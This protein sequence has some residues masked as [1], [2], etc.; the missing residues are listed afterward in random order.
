M[1]VKRYPVIVIGAGPAGAAAC[2][3]L[4]QG[5]ARTLLIEK[6]KLPRKKMCSGLLSRWTV[7]FVHRHFGPIPEDAYTET[8]FLNGFGFNFPSL[9]QTVLVPTTHPI[10]YVRRDQFDFFLARKSG[11]EIKDQ[12]R[13]KDIESEKAGFRI[14]CEW[15]RRHG[16]STQ[17]TF[18]ARYVVA[19]DGANS[20]AVRCVLPHAR[21][22]MPVTTAIQKFF[23]AEI[24]LD[25]NHF[26]LVFHPGVGFFPW[27]NMKGERV[28]VGVSGL[29]H[30]KAIRYFDQFLCV[31]QRHY[32]LKIRESLRAEAMAGYMMAY[33][34]HFVLGR[35][36]FLA[37]GDAA[38]FIHG[39]EGI[40]AALVSG[41]LAAQAIL[42][43]EETGSKALRFYREYARDEVVRCL[44]QLNPL[45]MSKNAP[46]FPDTKAFW[47]TVSPKTLL[48]IYKDLKA[49]ASQDIG[50]KESGIGKILKQ[51]MIHHLLHR[52]YPVDL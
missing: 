42:R 17:V 20:R 11:A 3:R 41:D 27:V 14:L 43:A 34:N 4:V 21:R 50:L 25:P 46:F 1:A 36:N 52:R 47:K 37:A 26:H 29:D 40:S 13:L 39:A 19:A 23:R 18:H 12:L 24:D 5:G 48:L 44:D 2:R 33:L 8:P 45:R 15:D 38:G 7:D 6:K 32:G 49:F 9:P 16:K 28:V 31:L 51:N 22:G 30:R 35:D 10:P